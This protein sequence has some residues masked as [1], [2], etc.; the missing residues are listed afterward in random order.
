[1]GCESNRKNGLGLPQSRQQ[2]VDLRQI[3]VT[4]GLGSGQYQ[5]EQRVIGQVQQAGQGVDI[6][7]AQLGLVRV[8]KPRQQQVVFQQPPAAAPAQAG[9]VGRVGLMR[10]QN[11]VRCWVN[12]ILRLPG[13]GSTV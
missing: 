2:R 10:G 8:K 11:G 13:S 12:I 6:V 7:V 9:A 1:M 3:Q 5:I 4:I